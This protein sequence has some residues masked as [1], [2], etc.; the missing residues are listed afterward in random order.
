M[1][2]DFE[3]VGVKI[4]FDWRILVED[5]ELGEEWKRK[6]FVV[7]EC[8]ATQ[9]PLIGLCSLLRQIEFTDEH[10]SNSK[11]KCDCKSQDALESKSL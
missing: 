6:D 5:F 9:M 1:C 11:S 3:R 8:E 10:L 2:E 4:S 7:Y